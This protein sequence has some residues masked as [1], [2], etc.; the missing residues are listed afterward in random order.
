MGENQ[1]AEMRPVS[2]GK[3]DGK[4]V[5]ILSGLQLEDQI[6]IKGQMRLY[7]GAKVEIKP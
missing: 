2:L 3:V 7:P 5:A 4:E 6:V 1:T